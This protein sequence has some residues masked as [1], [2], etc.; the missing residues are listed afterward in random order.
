MSTQ[1][2]CRCA[3]EMLLTCKWPLNPI[4]HESAVWQMPK[5]ALHKTKASLRLQELLSK[6]AKQDLQ[7]N[8]SGT[9]QLAGQMAEKLPTPPEAD[10]AANGHAAGS[11]ALEEGRKSL[12]KAPKNPLLI[13]F[14]KN[15]SSLAKI[16]N[17]FSNRP[18]EDWE[19]PNEE[20]GGPHP[21]SPASTSRLVS[22]DIC[23]TSIPLGSRC[24]FAS[25]LNGT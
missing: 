19:R 20:T 13:N 21:D 16:S 1:R 7:K 6:A 8:Q 17:P 15:A 3:V 5:C 11:A 14:D 9:G 4:T 25:S 24:K 18:P 2:H 10:A 23:C 22:Q 12:S